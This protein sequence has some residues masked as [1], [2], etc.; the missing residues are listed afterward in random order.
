MITLTD[1][2]EVTA[3][4]PVGGLGDLSYLCRPMAE[5]LGSDR[6]L[7][8]PADSD[9]GNVDGDFLLRLAAV[10]ADGDTARATVHSGNLAGFVGRGNVE[11]NVL[12]RFGDS[13][14]MMYMLMKVLNINVFG[15]PHGAGASF[16]FFDLCVL[17]L[18]HYLRKAL[19]QGLFRCY[20]RTA[21][22]D[23][24]FSGVLDAA[25]HLSRN[26]PFRGTV[27][28]N[29]RR[30]SADNIITQLIRHTLEYVKESSVFGRYV[31]SQP[32]YKSDMAAVTAAT[33]T[34][35]RCGRRRVVNDNL[36]PV[37]H[38]FYSE[39]LPLQQLCLKILNRDSM[40]YNDDSEKVHGIVINMAWLWEQYLYTVLRDCG[41]RHPSNTLGT[42]AV[43]L[44]A[45]GRLPRY[46][47]F[48]KD[49]TVAD[50]KYK[51]SVGDRDDIHQLIS[52]M[53]RQKAATGIFLHPTE[54]PSGLEDSYSLLGYGEE[55]G[56]SLQV[57]GVRIPHGCGLFGDF[58]VKMHGEEILLQDYFK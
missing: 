34:Y 11:V 26:T 29:V 39:Y 38:P 36:R 52:Y 48:Y 21:C 7:A 32:D 2:G 17:L 45:N 56:A 50:A 1:N 25:R 57:Y 55:A 16:C 24:R 4:L 40:F 54:E 15:L 46:P 30:R 27:A 35:Q 41:F 20:I 33:P 5:L 51:K 12:P 14:F 44:A 18:P 43:C 3:K 53:Y 23:S 58:A 6:L 28:Y 31:L 10:E 49:S 9:K 13:Y 47:D 19:A 8:V 37:V 42:G 22:N